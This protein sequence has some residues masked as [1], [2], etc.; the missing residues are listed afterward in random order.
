MTSTETLLFRVNGMP[1]GEARPRFTRQGRAYTPKKTRDYE[2]DIKAAALKAA[3][4]QG[5]L[6]TDQPMRVHV[7]AWFPAPK[8]Y[9]KKKR[10]ACE[11][12]DIYPT[13]KPDADNIAKCLDALNG[14]IWH[15]DAQ[16]VECI[17]RKRYCSGGEQ[18]H[19]NVFVEYMPTFSEMKAAALASAGKAA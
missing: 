11:A 5:W 3:M 19:L 15:D 4:L 12:G 18:P 7:C 2:A 17:V 16:V 1:Q 9:S 8:S 13:K 14:V 10:A 6:K